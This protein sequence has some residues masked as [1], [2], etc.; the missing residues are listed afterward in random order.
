MELMTEKHKHCVNP[1]H[2]CHT[3][4]EGLNFNPGK[5]WKNAS[6]P[7]VLTHVM[8]REELRPVGTST[9]GR[10][11]FAFPCTTGTLNQRKWRDAGRKGKCKTDTTE[12]GW[13]KI[14]AFLDLFC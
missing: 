13:D 6:C 9:R 14:F 2:S 12:S 7:V 11:G 3:K 5:S 8:D 10:G 1:R 4:A